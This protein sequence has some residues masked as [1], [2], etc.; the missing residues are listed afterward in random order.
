[1]KN[2]KKSKKPI[3]LIVI[4]VLI[5]AAAVFAKLAF[6]QSSYS[7]PKYKF[8]VGL[9][10]KIIKAQD[11][12]GTAELTKDEVNQII[13]LYFKEY[14]GSDIT[15]KAV[16]A[17]FSG[18]NMK[19]YIPVTYKNFNVLLTSEGSIF[20]ES[21]KIKY[22]PQYFKVG[23]I[24]LPKSYVME[25][26]KSRLKN[27]ATV[28]QDSIMVSTKGFPVG[29]TALSVKNE[30]LLV[31]LEKRQL[32]IEDI[33]KG[34]LD[35]IRDLIKNYSSIKN[36]NLPTKISGGNQ[37]AVENSSTLNSDG[38]SNSNTSSGS[39][40]ASSERQQAIGKVLSGLNA[41]SGSV[42]TGSQK[43]VISQMISVVESMKDPSYNPYSAE[44]S[45][46]AMYGKLSSGERAQLKAAVFSNVDTSSA[47]I[48]ANMIEK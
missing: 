11:T 19:F 44:G 16:E 35:S 7:P 31:T 1:M 3:F 27:S 45:V 47:D 9:F 40:S 46:K 14:R 6:W 17:D 37:G 12:G 23:K 5:L 41:A 34:K 22:T 24:T 28:E 25:K 2:W 20:K 29:I 10:D 21:D 43:A 38:T 18:D 8:S 42:S 13:S 4:I 36:L 48:L 32:N 30:K 33:L 26:L 15:V 39:S